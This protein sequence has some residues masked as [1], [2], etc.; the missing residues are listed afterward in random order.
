[1]MKKTMARFCIS[2]IAITCVAFSGS[3]AYTAP[4]KELNVSS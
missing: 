2:I 1:M 4:L 3:V